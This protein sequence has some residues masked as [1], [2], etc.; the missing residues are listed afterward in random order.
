[1]LNLVQD[2]NINQNELNRFTLSGNTHFTSVD[3]RDLN[4]MNK[5]NERSMLFDTY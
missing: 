4:C 5:T 2:I 1:M 3:F